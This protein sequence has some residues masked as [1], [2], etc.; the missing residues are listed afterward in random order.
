M[1]KPHIRLR[2][3]EYRW[4]LCEIDPWRGADTRHAYSCALMVEDFGDAV[5]V[6]SAMHEHHRRGYAGLD[7]EERTN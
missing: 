4:F 5:R 2:R 3:G 6:L 1:T 7:D